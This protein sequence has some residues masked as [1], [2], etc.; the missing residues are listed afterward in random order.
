MKFI[1]NSH[2]VLQKSLLVIDLPASSLLQS[3]ADCKKNTNL[4]ANTC[5]LIAVRLGTNQRL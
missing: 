5:Q 3:P 2:M 4:S 1:A